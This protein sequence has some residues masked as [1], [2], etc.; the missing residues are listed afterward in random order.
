MTLQGTWQ[1]MAALLLMS[2]H[3]LVHELADDLESF[4]HVLSW[5]AL[6]FMPH[7][8]NPKRL[9]QCLQDVFDFSW[10]DADGTAQG[11]K[12]KKSFLLE[13]DILTAG[14]TNPKMNS[15]LLR[16]LTTFAARYQ[17]PPV[18][19]ANDEGSQKEFESWTVNHAKKLKNLDSSDWMLATFQEALEDP[20]AWPEA[21][22]SVANEVFKEAV[23]GRKRKSEAVVEAERDA[24]VE[25]NAEGPPPHQRR[26]HSLL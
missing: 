20:V 18:V 13:R 26:R 14:L 12:H 1:F 21:D 16:L 10:V 24:D 2:P 23:Q 17:V 9:S 8:W 7:A 22:K 19:F 3:P 4:L 6:C 25:A 15:L 5:V 11:G